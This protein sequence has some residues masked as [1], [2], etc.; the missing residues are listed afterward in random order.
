M[1]DSANPAYKPAPLTMGG[2]RSGGGSGTGGTG[3]P[4][5]ARSL[6]FFEAA[7]RRHVARDASTRHAHAEYQAFVSDG[8]SGGSGGGGGTERV[9]AATLFAAPRV[10]SHLGGGGGGGDAFEASAFAA[11]LMPLAAPKSGGGRD[12]SHVLAE[13]ARAVPAPA[14]QAPERLP[15][16]VVLR[17]TDGGGGGGAV[18]DA[19]LPGAA[20]K[21]VVPR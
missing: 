13:L 7:V 17:P 18:R 6:N 12:L 4:R 15:A 5:D 11:A 21:E 3:M 2:G 14:F 8:G 20:P 10:H 19:A 9:L 1:C 16:P